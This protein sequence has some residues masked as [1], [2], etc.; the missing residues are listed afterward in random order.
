[1]GQKGRRQH[2][3]DAAAMGMEPGQIL[4]VTKWVSMWK[5]FFYNSNLFLQNYTIGKKTSLHHF[6]VFESVSICTCVDFAHC[7]CLLYAWSS[8]NDQWPLEGAWSSCQTDVLW[9]DNTRKQQILIHRHYT[10]KLNL[11]KDNVRSTNP[12]TTAPAIFYDSKQQQY[13]I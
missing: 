5:Y 4:V 11:S 8:C 12:G 13:S 10:G 6:C 1:M 2:H 7:L 9:M 3:S